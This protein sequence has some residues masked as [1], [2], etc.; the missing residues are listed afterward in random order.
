MMHGPCGALNPNSPCMKNNRCSKRY[1]KE[2]H[3]ETNLDEQGFATYRR[4]NNGRYVMKGG[5][6]LDN[7][8]VVPYNEIM[9]ETYQ[10]HINIEWCNKTIFVKYLLK[11]V[12]KGP[13]YSKVYLQRIR[14]GKDTPYDEET[15]T[16]NEVK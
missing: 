11:Y 8:W 7:R 12:S 2:F 6:G 13:Y 9:L 3:E 15:Y 5:Y 16:R 1:P 14:N 4:S 10:A